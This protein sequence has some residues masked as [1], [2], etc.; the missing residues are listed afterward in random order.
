MKIKAT[1]ANST[2]GTSR[3]ELYLLWCSVFNMSNL[4]DLQISAFMHHWNRFNLRLVDFGEDNRLVMCSQCVLFC[5][6]TVLGH[7]E[8][9]LC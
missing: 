7:Q 8:I 3:Q 4:S 6:E 1:G 9:L 2:E 5:R